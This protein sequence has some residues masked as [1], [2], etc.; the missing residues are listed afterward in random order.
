METT[1]LY[2]DQYKKEIIELIDNSVT[3]AEKHKEWWDG[4]MAALRDLKH[5]LSLDME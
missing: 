4:Y 1:I 2:V 3:D 5:N